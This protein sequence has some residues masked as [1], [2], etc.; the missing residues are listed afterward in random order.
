MVADPLQYLL[1]SRAEFLIVAN[2]LLRFEQG[3]S[4]HLP[5]VFWGIYDECDLA[6]VRQKNVRKYLEDLMANNLR[7]YQYPGSPVEGC[8]YFLCT[9]IADDDLP[10][11]HTQ[12]D[13]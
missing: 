12:K 6:I 10:W 2:H 1:K 5:S 7:F 4:K 11:D 3:S 8:H 13:F 9:E